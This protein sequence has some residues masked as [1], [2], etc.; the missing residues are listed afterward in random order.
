MSNNKKCGIYCIENAI[1]KKRYIGSAVDIVARW[2]IHSHQLNKNKHHSRH[3]QKA[4][5]KYHIENFNFQI[6]EIVFNVSDLIEREQY[7]ID[8]FQSWDYQ[9]GYNICKKAN[10]SLGIKRTD[11]FKRKCS[12]SKM[13]SKNV[14][15][16]V[17]L[18]KETIKK[19]SESKK[20]FKNPSKGNI[21]IKSASSKPIIQIGNGE[22]IKIWDS[23]ADVK[24]ELGYNGSPI[25][26]VAKGR[27][28]LAY[29][30]EWR[31][32]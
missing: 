18:S 2:R 21:G 26:S 3:L 28:K 12:E 30:Y 15:F 32:K 24:R 22:I 25:I 23:I 7:Y 10:S 31:Y 29:G 8:L 5:D 27:K 17:K 20:G 4:V 6:I 11:E 14:R 16:G 13:G 19:C 1:N 9:F